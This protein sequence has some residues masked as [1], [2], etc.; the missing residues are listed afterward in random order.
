MYLKFWNRD[1]LKIVVSLLRDRTPIEYMKCRVGWHNSFF[2]K[3]KGSPNPKLNVC[4]NK[5]ILWI[6]KISSYYFF[7]MSFEK[8]AVNSF[9]QLFSEYSFIQLIISDSLDIIFPI[10]PLFRITLLCFL[11]SLWMKFYTF[12][13]VGSVQ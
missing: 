1:V 9:M 2:S 12:H 3:L 7:S 5:G 10:I 13:R 4:K 6:L 11:Y 8:A